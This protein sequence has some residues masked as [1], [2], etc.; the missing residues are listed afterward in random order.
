MQ[1]SWRFSGDAGETAVRSRGAL[2]S[3]LRKSCPLGKQRAQGKPGA[4][5][6]RSLVCKSKKHTSKSPQ[7]H[8][9]RPGL[10]CAMVLTVSFVLAPETGLCCLRFLV[11]CASIVT[12]I[13]ASGYQAHTTSPSTELARSSSRATGVHRIP[14]STFVTI[15]IR[16][17]W[18]GGMAGINNAASTEWRSEI[19]SVGG[20]DRDATQHGV[21]WQTWRLVRR[22]QALW[23]MPVDR[24]AD[25]ARP[26][27]S[28]L[29]RCQ[30]ACC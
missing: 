11:R 24:S 28:L 26:I 8:R 3:G 4:W 5:C 7:V 10:P 6:T 13:S 16:P 25:A 14:R 18:R 27:A 2:A 12:T 23:P 30:P 20:V 9:K 15:A 21:S 29:P 22:P 1:R 17:S 19:F